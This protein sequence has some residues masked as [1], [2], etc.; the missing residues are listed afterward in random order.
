VSH[1]VIFFTRLGARTGRDG[2]VLRVPA[3][4]GA[5]NATGRED[6]KKLSVS[7]Q[8]EPSKKKLL[9]KITSKLIAVTELNSK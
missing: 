4:P 1:A 9:Y 6:E 2:S 5:V 7:N 3:S 8:Q